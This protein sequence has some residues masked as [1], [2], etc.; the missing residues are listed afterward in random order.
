MLAA[1]QSAVV[2]GIDGHRTTVEVH[3]GLGLPCVQLV[4]QP[5][6]ACREGIARVRAAIASA[7]LT[8]PARRITVNLAPADLRK[9][10]SALDVAMAI[11]VL[12]AAGQLPAEAVTGCAFLGELGLDGTVRA[13]PGIVPLVDALDTAAVVVP[14]GC[15]AEADLVG[16][17]HVR[18]VPDLRSLVDALTGTAPWPERADPRRCGLPEPPPPDLGEVRGQRLGR[19]AVEV[20]A[21]GGHHL[22]LSGPPGA[23]KTMLARRLPPLLPSL[24]RDEALEVVRVHSAA[25]VAV[26]DRL[27]TT[28]PFRA[29]HHGASAVSLIGG[30][31]AAIRPGEV[32]LAHRGVLFLDELAEFPGHVLD[33]LRQPLEEGVVRVARARAVVAMPARF[34][35]V[36]ATNPCPCGEGGRPGSCV[37]SDAMVARYLRRVSGPL[38]DRFDLRVHVDRP[39][40]DE[41]IGGVP[42]EPSS[43]VAARVAA[44]RALAAERG[45]VSSAAIP[46]NRLDELAELD[47]GPARFLARRLETGRLTARGLDRVRRV[48]RTV[49]DLDGWT[50]PL[51]TD[52]V[53]AAAE[54]RSDSVVGR[55]A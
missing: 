21:A 52:D 48:A 44:A 2:L 40:V 24:T 33:T 11:A 20:A 46:S 32:T 30:G 6:P 9:T 5:D 42:G 38:L 26:G 31:T 3:V 54:L 55:A 27:P 36:A 16:R 4:G 29:P 8:W 15:G 35:L 47:H 41:L 22:L 34:Q 18:E 49:A 51:R 39:D 1:I 10:G 45:V 25:G 43:V 50:G 14:H 37:C 53:A 7:G 12:V 17:A 23:G 13:V 28:P 19:W